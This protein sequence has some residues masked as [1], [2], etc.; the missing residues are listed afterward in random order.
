MPPS[1]RACAPRPGRSL[2]DPAPCG[3]AV[4]SD[5][6]GAREAAYEALAGTEP[7]MARLAGAYG[8]PDPF[9]WFDGGRTGTSKFAAMILHITGQ[10]ISAAA[11]FTIYDRITAASGAL[12]DASSLLTLGPASGSAPE[13]AVIRS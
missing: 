8:R 7:V 1:T 2:G 9:E 11:A 6:R 3:D 5:A 13:A 4:T 10:R 12:P